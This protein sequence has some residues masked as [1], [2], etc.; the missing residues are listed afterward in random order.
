MADIG[1]IILKR[2]LG[3]D[4]E[5]ALAGIDQLEEF[6]ASFDVP[7][8]LRDE[9]GEE[10][11]EHLEPICKMAV[12]DACNLTNPRPGLMG[13]I[14]EDLR[15]GVVMSGVTT[16][17]DLVGIEHCKLG[18]YQELQQKVEQLKTAPTWSWKKNARRSRPCST[19]SP[20]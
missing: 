11:R 3:S 20:T 7:L 4:R 19:A 9:I 17:E 10:G 15:G 14:A 6:F 5:T 18:F 1:R 16:L 13:G 12:N 8:R 2:Q